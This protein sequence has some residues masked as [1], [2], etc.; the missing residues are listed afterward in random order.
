MNCRV[1]GARQSFQ[2]FRQNTWF[3]EISRA[4]SDFFNGISHYLISIIKLQKNQSIKKQRKSRYFNHASHLNV[5][6][7]LTSFLFTFL[8][9]NSNSPYYMWDASRNL[10]PQFKTAKKTHGGVLILAKLHAKAC[11]F[12]KSNTPPRVY[13]MPSKRTAQIFAKHHIF[14]LPFY[15]NIPSK[16]LYGQNWI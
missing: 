1:G 3:L 7:Y 8:N 12:T 16:Q 4:L 9:S 15:Q 6:V 2:I 5:S 13:F 14:I 11:N 10:S